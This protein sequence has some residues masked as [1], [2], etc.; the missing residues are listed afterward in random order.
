MKDVVSMASP[1]LS[2]FGDHATF[3]R[4]APELAFRHDDDLRLEAVAFRDFFESN[5][6]ATDCLPNYRKKGVRE[7]RRHLAR[8]SIEMARAIMLPWPAREAG[9]SRLVEVRLS[10]RET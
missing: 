4:L 1:I 8:A 10:L 5:I 6:H 3:E 7:M 9:R 2:G